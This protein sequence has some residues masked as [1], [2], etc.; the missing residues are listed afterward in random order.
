MTRTQTLLIWGCDRR[1]WR[2]MT[3][4]QRVLTPLSL[5]S[6]VAWPILLCSA[7]QLL[8]G[9][10][11]QG[12][13]RMSRTPRVLSRWRLMATDRRARRPRSCS[14]RTLWWTGSTR[15]T[16]FSGDHWQALD[17]YL[18]HASG[19]EKVTPSL[20]SSKSTFSQ[21]FIEKCISEV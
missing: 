16:Q 21:P 18:L 4:T 20:P 1:K 15:C 5:C 19:F 12:E 2:R 10:C 8:L 9:R 14:R 6:R 3:N 17:L 7:W 13:P 11:A